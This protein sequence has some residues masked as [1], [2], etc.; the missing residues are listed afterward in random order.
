MAA[1]DDELTV[2]RRVAGEDD[3]QS[4]L[5]PDVSRDGAENS[6]IRRRTDRSGGG[7]CGSGGGGGAGRVA[8]A[9]A[10]GSSGRTGGE[11]CG[12]G[13]SDAFSFFFFSFSV[14]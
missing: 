8:A 3:G 13:E 4:R 2:W 12:T 14:P 5:L 11:R 1:D 7:R 9:P 6:G 10:C